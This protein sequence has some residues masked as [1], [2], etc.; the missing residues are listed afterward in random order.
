MTFDGAWR[1]PRRSKVADSQSKYNISHTEL[2]TLEL[3]KLLIITY[4]LYTFIVVSTVYT[5]YNKFSS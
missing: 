3:M 4:S 1:P 2:F 5:I